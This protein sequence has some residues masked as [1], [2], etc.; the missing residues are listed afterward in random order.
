MALK[1]T[2]KAIA[3]K[4][5]Q[6]RQGQKLLIVLLLLAVI[7]GLLLFPID[8][9]PTD[10]RDTGFIGFHSYPP[11]EDLDLEQAAANLRYFGSMSSVCHATGNPDV[12]A[13]YS[14]LLHQITRYIHSGKW[15][16][17][18]VQDA[19]QASRRSFQEID[20]ALA[21]RRDTDNFHG[22]DL[23]DNLRLQAIALNYRFYQDKIPVCRKAGNK[24]D[25]R[26]YQ[27]QSAQALR[28]LYKGDFTP[29]KTAQAL[30]E[31]ETSPYRQ[32]IHG[33]R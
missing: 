31:A 4:L 6:G 28:R 13:A 30:V 20:T 7:I 22:L 19:I 16:F 32:R 11:G 33:C 21:C 2:G 3:E 26:I 15:T 12:Q 14:F 8:R 17:R 10:T 1:H 24:V 18:E 29:G 23:D 25:T 5:A 9:E 27:E